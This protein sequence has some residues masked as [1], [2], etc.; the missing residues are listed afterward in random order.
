MCIYISRGKRSMLLVYLS[1]FSL[2]VTRNSW[3][4]KIA[5]VVVTSIFSYSFAVPLLFAFRFVCLGHPVWHMGPV[6]WRP[7]TVK[8]WQSSQSNRNSTIGTRQT[9]YHEALSSSANDEV[10]CDCTFADD[11][12]ASWYSVCRVAMVEWRLDCGD[13]HHLMVVGLHDAGPRF[14]CP[15]HPVWQLVSRWYHMAVCKLPWVAKQL[16]VHLCQK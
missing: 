2:R 7:T 6:S 1:K 15:G 3:M 4:W 14:V 10:K 5:R 12:N 11:D 9:E 13:C 16:D 8:W